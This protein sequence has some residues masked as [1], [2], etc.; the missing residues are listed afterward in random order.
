[1][2]TITGVAFVVVAVLAIF[3]VEETT[4]SGLGFN[5]MVEHAGE[6]ADSCVSLF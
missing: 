6:R 5:P 4:A 1:M 2:K 3:N